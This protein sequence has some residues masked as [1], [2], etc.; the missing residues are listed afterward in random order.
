M[1]KLDNVAISVDQFYT[2][3]EAIRA[4]I[5]MEQEYADVNTNQSAVN[6]TAGSKTKEQK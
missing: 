6:N 1:Q 3:R 4:T 5:Q 2:I